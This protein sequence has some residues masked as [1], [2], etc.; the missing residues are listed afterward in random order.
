MCRPSPCAWGSFDPLLRAYATCLDLREKIL[1]R[2][3]ARKTVCPLEVHVPRLWFFAR[4]VPREE[5]ELPRR[6]W[7]VL[8][9]LVV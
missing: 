7:F 3:P 5:R 8:T 1:K 4:N 2:D 9:A 6:L